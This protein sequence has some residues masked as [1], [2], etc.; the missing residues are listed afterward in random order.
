MSALIM[1]AMMSVCFV[2]CSSDDNNGDDSILTTIPDPEGTKTIEMTADGVTTYRIAEGNL[3]L[4]RN[5]ELKK[6][7]D[8]PKNISIG[9]VGK[10][11]GV[12]AI[13]EVPRS[14]SIMS[15]PVKPG[16][17]FVVVSVDYD[18]LTTITARLFVESYIKDSNGKKVGIRVKCHDYWMRG[19]ME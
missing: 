15:D 17:G 3:V 12:G 14:R 19:R 7:F 5:F 4:T 8:S 1:V 2:S 18:Y 9:Y 10:T 16:D 6:D 13:T 11:N